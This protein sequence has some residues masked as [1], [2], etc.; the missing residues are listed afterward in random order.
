MASS[1]RRHLSDQALLDIL[2]ESD[3]DVESVVDSTDS[4]MPGDLSSAS[5][6]T[7][8][9]D[10]ECS[11]SVVRTW[12]EMGCL[13][14]EPPPRFPFTGSPGQKWECDHSPLAYM[15]LFLPEE[16]IDMIVQETNRYA[17]QQLAAPFSRFSRTRKW[18]PV[19]SEDIWQFLGLII[20]QGV[21]GK[22]LQKWNW[23]TNRILATPFFG[24]VM[25][26]YR[27]SL[28]MKFLHFSNNVEFDE[29]THPAPK[30]KKIWELYQ[31][32]MSNFRTTYTLERD[33]TV[34]ES[35]MAYKGRLSWIQFI[36]SKGA[37]F[38]VKSF[39]LC[40]SI[41]GY[42]W[43][44]VIYTGK[45]TKFDPKYSAYGLATSSVL[46][47]IDPFLDKGYCLTTDNFYTSPELYE[48]L[49]H[50]TDAYG[51]VRACRRQ[52]PPTF[53]SKKLKTGEIVAWQKGKVMALRWRDKKDV[54]LLSTVHNAATV[55]TMTR[56]GKEVQ[57]PQ[58]M[59]FYIKNCNLQRLSLD[60]N[61]KCMKGYYSEEGGL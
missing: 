46:T 42:I 39:M 59:F 18:E 4:G 57:K 3:S 16:V 41:S 43:N 61:H 8:E 55:L 56:G 21:V 36:A 25:P 1:S 9:S 49:L 35:L 17:E 28:I 19:T 54:C 58:F 34:D 52:M 32:I 50:K 15:E 14:Q 37:R 44:S 6:T 5:E 30:L 45:G 31:R 27:F 26:E 7:S 11:A 47:L 13:T 40:E 22:P 60:Y 51:T 29:A 10:R 48:Y 12:C 24:S 33:I 2:D 23:S 53:S 38:G 20:L